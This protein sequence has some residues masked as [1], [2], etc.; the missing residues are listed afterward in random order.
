M[1]AKLE[2]LDTADEQVISTG[3]TLEQWVPDDKSYVH[4]YIDAYVTPVGEQ[5]REVFR[6]SVCTPK[7]L[8]AQR[9]GSYKGYVWA[10]NY[11]IVWEWSFATVWTAIEQLVSNFAA[12]DWITLAQKIGHYMRWEFEDI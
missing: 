4:V 12:D 1:I 5:G 8:D 2:A 9:D 3:R 10:R 7:W 6:L 11:L